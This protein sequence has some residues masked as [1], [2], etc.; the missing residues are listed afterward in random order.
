MLNKKKNRFNLY[1]FIVFF[2]G[3]F[4]GLS[5]SFKTTAKESV[6]KYLNIFHQAYQ[7]IK[8]NYV[9]EVEPSHFFLGAIKGMTESLE[10]PFS[11][12]LNKDSL[13]KLEEIT[14]GKYVGIGIEITIKN[15]ELIIIAPIENSPAAKAGILTGDIISQIDGIDLKG[16][17]LDEIVNLIKGPLKSRLKLGIK[18]E[19]FKQLLPFELE[20]EEINLQHVESA[21]LLNSSQDQIAYLKIKSFSIHSHEKV[22]SFLEKINI[23]NIDKLIIDL[24]NNAGGLLSSAINMADLFLPSKTKIVS[25]QGKKK[26]KCLYLTKDEALFK[27]KIIILVNQG[28]ASASEILAA[29]IKDNQR[30]QL[31]GEKT[32]GKAS[33][34]KTFNLDDDLALALTIAKYYTPSGTLIHE[35]GIEPNYDVANFKVPL[36]EQKEI[37]KIKQNGLL[38]QFV[39]PKILYNKK[40]QESFKNFLKKN[41]VHLSSLTSNFLLKNKIY[42][43]KKK[44]IYD[45]EFDYQ[46]LEA[47]KKIES[48]ITN[49]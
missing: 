29:A 6:H 24:R 30:G 18:R 47:L 46:L 37:E 21:I 49:D 38:N 35:K 16:K 20:R 1:I 43:F 36:E 17:E 12:L 4:L 39:T 10:D 31:L 45:L 5:L 32:F 14:T 2:S 7:I 28:S 15:K 8:N 27:G 26:N 33:V 22:K 19:G 42:Q 3:L 11:R 34:Q 41:N 44:P 23:K 13:E 9:E 48:K 25:T 40:S